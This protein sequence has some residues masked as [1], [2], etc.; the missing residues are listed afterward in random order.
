[1]LSNPTYEPDSASEPRI[2]MIRP[3]A[4][5]DVLLT[6]PALALV[7][8]DRPEAHIT[9]IARRDVLPLVAASGL[10]DETYPYDLPAWSVLFAATPANPDPLARRV[11]AGAAVI[12][13]MSDTDAGIAAN[14]RALGAVLV[15]M[16]PARPAPGEGGH[17]A[18]RLAEAL[19]PLGV[20]PATAREALLA[21]L[22]ELLIAAADG[23]K[24]S[25][26][27]DRLFLEV[28]AQPVV[29]LHPGS[30]GAAKRWP[31]QS[32]ASLAELLVPEGVRALL[33]EGPQD[34]EV[35]Q[36]VLAS[37]NMELPVARG[38]SVPALAAVLR[39]CAAYVGNDSGVSHL[40]ALLGVPT[41]ALFGPTDPAHWA[42][43]GPRVHVLC[44]PDASLARLS[45]ATVAASV[46]ELLDNAGEPRWNA[47]VAEADTE[48]AE[49]GRED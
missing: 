10:A 8:R 18:L 21:L 47:E 7:R 4:L 27:W 17:V 25:E 13:W 41:L 38:L 30:G 9:L 23:R 44:A 32:F 22:P 6:V 48:I 37:A 28:G 11:F 33:I 12:A 16:A 1:M 35:C 3:G 24:A 46:R 40:A 42:P 15:R 19:A 29:A 5:G 45:A 2:V 34:G 31:A 26:I 20:T 14:L 49:E 36:A 43:L 39:R